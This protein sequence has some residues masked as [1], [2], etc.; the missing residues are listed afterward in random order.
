MVSVVEEE[1][2]NKTLKSTI[3][4]ED[5]LP[6]LAAVAVGESAL[7]SDIEN[8]KTKGDGGRSVGLGQVMRGPNW[9]GHSQREICT[10]RRLQLMLSLHVL[11]A[12][13]QRSLKADAAFRCYTAGDPSKN[14]YS[15]VHEYRMYRNVKRR[16]DT[17]IASQKIQACC[18]SGLASFYVREKNT[19]DL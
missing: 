18:A 14:S 1:F 17:V 7:R 4:Q 19:C 16:V 9:K 3:T 10:N 13:W 15:A 2:S 11:D 5:A 8:C 12:C 6:M